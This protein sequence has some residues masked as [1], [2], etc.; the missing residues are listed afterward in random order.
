MILKQAG[1]LPVVCCLIRAVVENLEKLRSAHV[2]HE[3][4]EKGKFIRES[5]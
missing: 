5:E 2:K 4:G 3:L 1:G